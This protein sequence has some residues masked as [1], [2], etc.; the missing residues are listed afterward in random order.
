MNATIERRIPDGA[1]APQVA[2]ANPERSVFVSANAG[3]G[4][5][6]VLAQRV[7]NLLLKGEDPAKILCITFTKA[8]AANMAKRVF[9]TLSAWSVLDDASLD[10]R[11]AAS[12]GK[13][14]DTQQRARARRLFATA[15]ETP[16]GLKVQTIHAFCTRLL[17]QFPFEADVAASFEV[18]DDAATA[19]LLDKL[20]LGVM[21]EAAAA[22]EGALG[23]ALAG[24]IPAAADTTFKEVIAE[25][26]GKRDLI[27]GWIKRAGGVAR[28]I[29]ELSRTFGLGAGD[30]LESVE[31]DYLAGSLI[32]Q[33]EWQAL[34]DFVATSDKQGDRD[35]AAFLAGARAAGR[36]GI[37]SYLKIFCTGELKP[38]KNVLTANFAKA[39]PEWAGRLAAE[40]VRV[41]AL[42]AKEFA[43]RAR[44]RSAALLTVAAAVIERY[45][46][47]KD[48]RGLLDYED[49][50]D[51]VLALF[52]DT[53]AAWVLY[54]LDLGI[55]H[56]LVDEAQ[57]TSPKQWEIIRAIVAEFLPGGA[58]ENI[59]RTLF[60]VGD[61]K[62][63][64][65]S[66][67]GAAPLAFAENRA[68]FER[69]H[70]KSDVPFG[71]EKLH[72]SFRSA[73]GVLEAVDTVFRQPQAFRGLTSDPAWTVH[74]ALPDAAPGEVEIWDLIAPDEKDTNK[75]G[76]D[77]PFDKTRETSPAIKLAGRIARTVKQWC[78]RGT[79]PQEVLVLVRQR[80]ALFEAVIRALK[81]EG[82]AVA[83]ADR[84]V[85][86][87]HIAIMDLM[88]LGDALL[89]PEDDL[90]LATVLKSP[91]FGLNDEQ[92]FK[93][94]YGRKGP[95]RSVLRAKAGDDPMF[96]QAA[97]VLDELAEKARTLPPFAF[98]ARV[99]G[100]LEGRKR[101]LAR[102][103]IEATDP[104]DEF[105]NLALDYERRETA[106]LQGFL[107]W[108]RAAQSEVK[109]DMEIARD[110]VRVMTVHGAKGLEARNVIL[111][112][113]T[114][115]RPEGAYPPRLLTVPVAGAAPGAE[116]LVW[117]VAKDKD[118]GPMAQARTRAL[119]AARDEYRR[120]LYVAMTRAAERLVV[121]GTKGV[122]K[123]PE[124]CWYQLVTDALDPVS[125]VE[126]A[127]DGDGEVKRFRKSPPS[128][129]P[130]KSG[131]A[132]AKSAT[133][134]VPP[135]LRERAA[136]EPHALRLIAPSLAEADDTR[137]LG[138][139]D[140]ETALA[141]GLLM[142]RL[143]QSL[144]DI[145]ADRRAEAARTFLARAAEE[146]KRISAEEE[147]VLVRQAITLLE[148]PRF[149][150]LFAPGSRAEVPIAGRLGDGRVSGQI[151]RLAV[152]QEAVFI[153]DFKTSRPAPRRLED[154]PPAY[155]TQLA[156]Y[157]AVLARLYPDRPVRAA[158]I[159]TE[160]PD[161]ME[162]PAAALEA[163]LARLTSA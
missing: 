97:R 111:A 12:T 162:I 1:R 59:K 95:L 2:A 24:V 13:P 20:T 54:K 75:E 29:A 158:L 66:F 73:A 157:R 142:H 112:D 108:V 139:A 90:A 32:P 37:A 130:S 65:F 99:L 14:S 30:T 39:N 103:G 94:A 132:E 93:L 124:G 16:G 69:L 151:D 68:Y 81:H 106:S 49:L 26:I 9:D 6:H 120:L 47:E 138:A 115:T 87:E 80:G 21:L 4:K 61:E 127:E 159:W 82:I 84:L 131:K 45:R 51:K 57:D 161:L 58:R 144:P 44:D 67:Q 17:H 114:T 35:I 10:A 43:V 50:I 152:T 113:S 19:Q 119:D 96:A 153:A 118:A 7:I 86:T 23:R 141:R 148:E 122:N 77:A 133:S 46:A 64:I 147:D 38:R 41:C 145:P 40:Q 137:P 62:Q 136:A 8:A 109:R 53:S 98:Y 31:K 140:S 150:A 121:C 155:V 27:T 129:A 42:V 163:S 70:E 36:D 104:L 149:S 83:G 123:I 60:V 5:T 34:A 101:I 56:V 134:E 55:N 102:L 100:A 63:S 48:R 156:L 85:L 74:Q 72:Y 105:L 28:A 25:A 110:E 146:Q 107:N 160:V 11:I 18:L 91:L 143:L 126:P 88:V 52:R 89:L 33:A 135:W 92:L 128:A 22:P 78:A 125:I 15:L 3:S 71:V 116:A 117:G 154:V 76:W 79:R